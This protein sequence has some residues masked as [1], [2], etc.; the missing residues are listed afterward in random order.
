MS[1]IGKKP[2]AVPSGVSV[3]LQGRDLSVK[4]PKGEL[5]RVRVT[6]VVVRDENGEEISDDLH[7]CVNDANLY[8][9]LLVE[10]YGDPE[11]NIRLLLDKDA[12][13]EKFIEALRWLLETAR[14]GDTVFIS[15]SGHGAQY[16]VDDQP[17]L[18]I[19]AYCVGAKRAE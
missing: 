6:E 3:S 7:G 13:E 12:N 17:E 9:K 2:V 14:P 10:K 4:G 8:K 15:F 16:A 18:S 5:A 19:H 11:E 1:L